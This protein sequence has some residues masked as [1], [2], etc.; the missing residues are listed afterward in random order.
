MIASMQMKM[1]TNDDWVMDEEFP[2][3][4]DALWNELENMWLDSRFVTTLF[5]QSKHLRLQSEMLIQ[6]MKTR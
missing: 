2:G 6:K 4:I 3:R 1:E 5:V